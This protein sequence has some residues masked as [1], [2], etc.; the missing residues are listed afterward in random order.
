MSDEHKAYQERIVRAAESDGLKAG[1]EVRTGG[2]ARGWVRTDTLVDNGDGLLIGWEVQLS[3]AP[4]VGPRSVRARAAKAAKHGIVPAWHTDRDDYASRQDTHWTRSD[5]LPAHLIAKMGDLRVVSGFRILDFWR[6]DARALY[7]CP[8]R[9]FSGCGELHVTPQPKDILFDDLV[10]KTGSGLVVP[11]EHQDGSSTHRFWVSDADRDRYAE[12]I[13]LPTAGAPGDAN[14]K[15]AGHASKNAPT[16]RPQV[17]LT[18]PGRI[19][20]WRDRSHWSERAQPCRFC[21]KPTN[22]LDDLGVPAHKVCFE[23]AA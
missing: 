4:L 9:R 8:N 6:C 13:G 21:R 5:R 16:C 12:V 18:S 11:I 20:D 23:E 17:T 15:A 3:S 19:V 2:G 10:R 22:L 1:S 14:A 7:P